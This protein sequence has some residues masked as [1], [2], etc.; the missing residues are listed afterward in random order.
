VILPS[1]ARVL[2]VR[3]EDIPGDGPVAAIL[4]YP[5]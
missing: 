1:G 2:A 3:S 4:R 5:L